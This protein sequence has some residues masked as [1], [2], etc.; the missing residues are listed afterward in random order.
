MLEDSAISH[1]P[2]IMNE[3]GQCTRF[4]YRNDTQNSIKIFHG[5]FNPSNPTEIESSSNKFTD[6]SRFSI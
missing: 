6:L 4:S 2:V 1:P 3:F 5:N